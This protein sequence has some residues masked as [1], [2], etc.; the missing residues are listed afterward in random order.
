MQDVA[1][2]VVGVDALDLQDRR[3]GRVGVACER[4]PRDRRPARD[5]PAAPPDRGRLG[6][7]VDQHLAL[8]HHRDP[9]GKGEDA[10]DVV[11]DQDHRHLGAKPLDQTHDALALGGGEAGERLVEQQDPGPGGQRHADLEQ[12]LPA[13]GEARRARARGPSGRG[14]RSARGSAGHVRRGRPRR[15]RDRSAAGGGLDAEADVLAHRRPGNRLVIWN[16][17]AMPRVTRRSAARPS[18]GARS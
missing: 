1:L 18:H 9:V 12:A 10:V 17:R 11:L 3:A 6:R 8:A 4:V 16:E 13:V 5:R 14:I 2:A 15:A 7:A